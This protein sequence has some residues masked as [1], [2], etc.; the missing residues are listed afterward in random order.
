V[1]ARAE[2]AT[3]RRRDE[4]DEDVSYDELVERLAG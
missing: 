3:I 1:F 2:G 4:A